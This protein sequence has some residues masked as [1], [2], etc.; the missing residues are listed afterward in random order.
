MTLKQ[1]NIKREYRPDDNIVK[2]FYIPLLQL[3]Q[4]YDRAV[5]FFSS[6]ILAE[7]AIGIQEIARKDGR[8]RIVAS[9]HL[10]EE[11]ITAIKRGYEKR[12][13]IIKRNILKNL[14]TPK[15]EF[16]KVHLNL[17]ANLIADNILDIKIAFT[18]KETSFGMY[19][20][21]MGIISD[22]SGNSVAF[23]G[24]LNETLNALSFNYET[25]DVYCSWKTEDAER[26]NDKKEAFERIWN[27]IESN[28]KII[29]FPELSSELIN[30][31]KVTRS[32]TKNRKRKS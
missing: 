21:K 24:S 9:P 14:Q 3:A 26:V 6:T 7:I 10:S 19:H 12:D 20:E 15:N 23:S 32:T 16:E 5:G 31:Y 4:T 30:K 13:E 11:D 1:L 28:I 17:L 29:S 25:I 2:S 18:E 22:D 27:D 8:I